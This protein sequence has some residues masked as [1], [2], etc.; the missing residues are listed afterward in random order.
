MC[1]SGW[2]FW[3]RKTGKVKQQDWVDFKCSRRV[4]ACP[5]M[6][7]SQDEMSSDQVFWIINSV[8]SNHSAKKLL[9]KWCKVALVIWLC[10][11]CCGSCYFRYV[12]CARLGF[13]LSK[14]ESRF[15]G[16][17]IW[18]RQKKLCVDL[19]T[20]LTL[21]SA[22][23]S[24]GMIPA[25]GAGGPGFKSRSGPFWCVVKDEKFKLAL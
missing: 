1:A 10:H 9:V 7:L 6:I 20:K 3:K 17:N 22:A 16:R 15:S 25:L 14:V 24:R 11:R 21:Q 4:R 8:Q 19:E 23:W 13:N 5:P 2:I 12:F 18:E